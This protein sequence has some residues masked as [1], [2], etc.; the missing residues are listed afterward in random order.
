MFNLATEKLATEREMVFIVGSPVNCRLPPTGIL[1]WMRLVKA[2]T[3]RDP[4]TGEGTLGGWDS[5]GSVGLSFRLVKH[6]FGKEVARC[7]GLGNS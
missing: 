4:G 2:S 1:Y 7:G 6:G 5:Q 3:H